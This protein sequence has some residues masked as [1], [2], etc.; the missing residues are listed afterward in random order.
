M[1]IERDNDLIEITAEMTSAGL[2]ELRGNSFGDDLSKVVRDI[3]LMM[4]LE[5]RSSSSAEPT[6]AS[7]CK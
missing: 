3:Y 5:R 7:Y 2:E 4:E 6:R 1:P